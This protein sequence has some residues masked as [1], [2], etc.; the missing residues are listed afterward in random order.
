MTKEQKD[1][2]IKINQ[3]QKIKRSEVL[4]SDKETLFFLKNNG[5]IAQKGY[6][7]ENDLFYVITALGKSQLHKMHENNFRFWFP[8]I[9]SNIMAFTALI[10]SIIALTKQ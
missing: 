9:V 10:I 7:N 6:P 1:F 2:L 5:Y 4:E 3:L 8:I